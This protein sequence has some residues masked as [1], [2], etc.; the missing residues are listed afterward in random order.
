LLTSI[1]DEYI[2]SD[3]GQR[4]KLQR[5]SEDPHEDYAIIFSGTLTPTGQT[6]VNL[7]NPYTLERVR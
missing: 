3:A 4:E 1:Q 6:D 5:D 2:L 7:L